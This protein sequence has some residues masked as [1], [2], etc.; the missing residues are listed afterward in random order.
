[1]MGLNYKK[2]KENEVGITIQDT[3]LKQEKTG[4]ILL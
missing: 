3:E 4:K 2:E 1:M